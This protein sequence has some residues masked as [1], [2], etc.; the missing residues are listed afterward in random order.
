MGYFSRADYP[1][2]IISGEIPNNS[3]TLAKSFSCSSGTSTKNCSVSFGVPND[4]CPG[5]GKALAIRCSNYRCAN[6]QEDT[7]NP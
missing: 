2:K 6:S 3:P 5:S 7:N 4:V 1:N